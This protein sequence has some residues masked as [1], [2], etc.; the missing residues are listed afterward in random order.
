MKIRCVEKLGGETG[1]VASERA[2]QWGGFV[3][4]VHS[5]K[6]WWPEE[7]WKTETSYPIGPCFNEA[8]PP[9]SQAN[10]TSNIV[11]SR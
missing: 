7:S 1:G 11:V 2:G 4:K 8:T 5:R 10:N 9:T 3:K 6:F